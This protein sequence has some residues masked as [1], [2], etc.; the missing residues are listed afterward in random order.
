[1]R[2]PILFG[3]NLVRPSSQHP[4]PDFQ[5]RNT[6]KGKIKCEFAV[7]SL[8]VRLWNSKPPPPFVSPQKCFELVDAEHV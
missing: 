7:F 5:S 4:K 8:S 2:I 3:V 1:M 6:A